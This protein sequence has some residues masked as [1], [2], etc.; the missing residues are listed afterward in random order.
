[1]RDTK[2][3]GVGKPISGA[4]GV[5]VTV[6]GTGGR[7]SGNNAPAEPLAHAPTRCR[8]TA[9]PPADLPALT[10]PCQP[11]RAALVTVVLPTHD[12]ASA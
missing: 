2:G 11:G 10:A 8:L 6:P 7:G 12:V 1:M 9:C 3:L 4:E 5:C